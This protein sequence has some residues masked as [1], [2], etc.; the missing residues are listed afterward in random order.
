MVGS[1]LAAL[2]LAAGVFTSIAAAS[3]GQRACR[4]A[5]CILARRLAGALRHLDDAR[6][7]GAPGNA[8]LRMEL[9]ARVVA[10][11]D[12]D[13]VRPRVCQC[14]LRHLHREGERHWRA[15]AHPRSADR[16]MADVVS[17]RRQD[18]VR[19]RLRGEVRALCRERERWPCSK[20]DAERRRRRFAGLVARRPLDRVLEE[21]RRTKPAHADAPEWNRSEERSGHPG[22]RACMVARRRRTR[23]LCPGLFGRRPASTSSTFSGAASGG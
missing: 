20:A 4:R 2:A 19:Q 1:R 21:A 9:V 16:P 23:V 3:A 11:R 22:R 17:E 6:W 12:E 8:E 13:R 7:R 10:Q 5:A 14:E 15:S 18:P